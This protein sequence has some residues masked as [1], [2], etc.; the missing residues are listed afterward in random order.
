MRNIFKE[1]R[2]T[3]DE[4]IA[5]KMKCKFLIIFAVAALAAFLYPPLVSDASILGSADSFAVLGGSTVTNTGSTTIIG[6]LGLSPGSSITGLGSIT[7]TGAV[8]Q[9]DA[10]AALAQNAVTIAYNGLAAMPFTSNLTGQDLGGLTLTSGVYHFNSSAQLTGTLT[11]DA[12][13]NNNAFWVFQM[14]STLTTASNSVVQVI[15]I[16]SN[17][18]SDDG[19]F[20]QVGSS[21]TLGTTT[22]F[23]G[24]IL[25]LASI[26][27]NNSA[28]ILNGRALAQTAAVTMDTNTIEDVCFDTNGNNIGPGYNGGLVYDTNGHIVAIGPSPGPSPAPEPATMLLLGL[29]LIGLVGVRRKIH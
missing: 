23:E 8:H 1:M 26:T 15:N 25:A 20:W 27:L 13:H 18:G 19:L 17:N 2:H 24:N 4:R 3:L 10:V 21:A 14:G 28:T 9:T 6:D 12:Q 5:S 22:A 11:L 29:G 7:L 16:G